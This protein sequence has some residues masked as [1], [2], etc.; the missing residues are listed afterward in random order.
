MIESSRIFINQE[1]EEVEDDDNQSIFCDHCVEEKATI[2]CKDC[3]M[4]L[5]HGCSDFMHKLKNK[6]NHQIT[7]ELL[8]NNV[9]LCQEHQLVKDM[10]C[11][12]CQMLICSK[13]DQQ[14]QQHNNHSILSEI[15]AIQMMQHLID[16]S[17]KNQMSNKLKNELQQVDQDIKQLQ[18]QMDQKQQKRQEI[19]QDLEYLNQQITTTT[20]QLTRGGGDRNQQWKGLLRLF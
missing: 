2:H 17:D 8:R 15:K 11:Q 12:D 6:Q 9:S 10:L 14:P 16:T 20:I 7:L 5:C 13:C 19:Q 4:N 18:Q 1:E 3:Q